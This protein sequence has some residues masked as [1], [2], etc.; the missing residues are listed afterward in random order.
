MTVLTQA[1][2]EP[3]QPSEDGDGAAVKGLD[4]REAPIMQPF[5]E[6]SYRKSHRAMQ[7]P[8]LSGFLRR[9]SNLM[10][11]RKPDQNVSP[12]LMCEASILKY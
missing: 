3:S 10:K 8:R 5:M 11:T 6:A 12:I 4:P 7:A 1:R 2:R 9:G